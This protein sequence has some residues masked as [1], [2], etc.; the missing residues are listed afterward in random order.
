M[1]KVKI[2]HLITGNEGGGSE[3]MLE[4]LIK[5]S[6]NYHEHHVILLKL[7]NR[8]DVKH[9]YHFNFTKNPIR[10]LVEF[11]KLANLFN[12]LKPDL[13]MSWLY[14]SDLLIFFLSKILRFPTMRILWNVRCSYLDLKDYSFITRI[15]LYLT[16][17]I[18]KNIGNIIF[19][20]YSGKQ[21]HKKLGYKNKN[22]IVI[23][24]GFDLKKFKT[25]IFKK[26]I[27]KNKYNI[28][29]KYTIAMV[30]RND[31]T[32]N[33]KIFTNL[34][35][36]IF[37][38]NSLDIKYLIA[39]KNTDKIFIPKKN[40]Q[41]YLSLGYKKNI[42][43]YFNIMDVL[44]LISKGEGFSNVI[45]EAMCM[46]V[47]IVCNDVGDNRLIVEKSGIVVSKNPT[48]YELRTSLIK[49]LKFKKKYTNGRMIIK[50]KYKI[51]VIAKQYEVLFNSI[52]INKI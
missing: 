6:P 47:P 35:D 37:L 45:G 8:L 23:Q 20:S 17:K 27:L 46:N 43:E 41:H 13:A 25:N 52:L 22:M 4:K 9:C 24:N 19:N 34:S 10:F 48:I 15:V 36:P 11:L 16:T 26:K 40:K 29:K 21:Y 14:H 31:P 7:G 38:K 32:K 28:Q 50:K 30:A 51:E 39:G 49:V 12:Y 1:N 3:K 33:F 2:I 5:H 42:H 44:V 18:S